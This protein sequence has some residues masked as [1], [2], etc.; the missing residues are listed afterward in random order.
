MMAETLLGEIPER[1]DN[2]LRGTG[3]CNRIR[4]RI[5]PLLISRTVEGVAVTTVL[6]G[7]MLKLDLSAFRF[8]SL[9]L[10]KN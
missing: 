6:V 7:R 4:L 5:T 10:T 2:L 8:L 9:M 1:C 3:S